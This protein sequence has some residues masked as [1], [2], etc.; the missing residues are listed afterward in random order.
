[1]LLPAIFLHGSFEYSLYA[2]GVIQ[3]A[4]DLQWIA[5]D[6]FSVVIP[7][8]IVGVGAIWAVRSYTEVRTTSHTLP[9]SPPNSSHSLDTIGGATIPAELA[10][11]PY[12]R[13]RGSGKHTP[14]VH[15]GLEVTVNW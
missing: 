13:G 2:I 10:H 4:F 7:L 3:Y 6:I 12:A 15:Y 9:H 1:M 11:D 14:V 8:V 5:L